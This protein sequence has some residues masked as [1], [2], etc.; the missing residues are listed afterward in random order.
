MSGT[1]VYGTDA[2][3]TLVVRRVRVRVSEGPDRGAEVLLDKGTR[4]I[5]SGPAADLRLNDRRVSRAHV[6]LALTH[7]G[8]RVKDLGS[9]NGTF[10]GTS[11]IE[12]LVLQPPATVKVGQSRI[13]LVPDDLPARDLPS[14]RDRFGGLVGESEAMRRIF[15]ILERVAASDVPVLLEGEPGV[16]KTEA[17]IAIHRASA[18]ASGPLE[19][20]DLARAGGDPSAIERA[21]ADAE[22]GTIVLERLDHLHGEA[23]RVLLPLLDE[24]E[25]RERHVR[26]L[27]TSVADTRP[28][29]ERGA[30]SRSVYFHLAGVRVVIPPLRERPEDVPVVVRHVA[31]GIHHEGGVALNAAEV[32][33]LRAHELPGNV[34]ELKKLVE[35]AIVVSAA[36][37]AATPGAPER[38]ARAVAD[39]DSMSF[40]DA[41]EKV[42]DAFE[43]EYVRGLLERHDGNLSSASREAGI[44]RHHLLALAR[45]HGLR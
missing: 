17:A 23:S 7:G 14:D 34:R 35:H 1:E 24:C 11:R 43:R 42:L 26:P 30:L 32:L 6:E 25:R 38:L 21:F 27:A 29:V 16:G 12:S 8:V 33:R 5:G 36:E 9:T 39:A 2:G 3:G 13:E 28:L 31:A 18:R 41:K 22:G 45:K 44:V 15:G 37:A 4:V 20:L 19:I 10:V 40:K